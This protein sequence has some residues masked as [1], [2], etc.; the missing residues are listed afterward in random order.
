MDIFNHK[1]YLDNHLLQETPKE[2]LFDWQ[3]LFIKR[4]KIFKKFQFMIFF[5]NQLL[6]NEA[7]KDISIQFLQ[8]EIVFSNQSNN[9]CYILYFHSNKTPIKKFYFHGNNQIIIE[10]IAISKSF[11]DL[12]IYN[13]GQNEIYFISEHIS[14]QLFYQKINFFSSDNLNLYFIQKP[15]LQKEKNEIYCFIS[16]KT[17]LKS[18]HI[19]WTKEIQLQ[20]DSVEVFHKKN[21]ISH[22]S[23]LGLN[24][25][26]IV[27]QFNSVIEKESS[28][29][30]TYQ[31]INH[32][33][34]T[35]SA[36]SFCKPNLVIQNKN[37]VASH[38]NTI[39]KIQQEDLFYLNQR[40]IS[41]IEAKKMILISKIQSELKDSNIQKQF[42]QFLEI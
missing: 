21:S 30:E 4:K 32:I 17:T 10:N 12:S 34:L 8:N 35:S 22:L 39:G 20:D 3:I 38:G 1:H 37:V 19:V 40:G 14:Q 2:E 29:C 18:K 27:S 24:Q 13:K 25:G 28:Y 36:K 26:K 31:K 9:H 6:F 42:L 15:H 5:D 23:Y 16:E 33:L 41:D 11:S 7:K